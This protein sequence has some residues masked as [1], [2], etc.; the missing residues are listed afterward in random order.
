MIFLNMEIKGYLDNNWEERL[1]GLT[2]NQKNNGNTELSG[3]LDDQEVFHGIMKKTRDLG[4]RII[5]IKC[6][7]MTYD[8]N[9]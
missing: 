1:Y 6:Y 3:I 2:F 5:S 7:D 9:Q 8:N 4:I